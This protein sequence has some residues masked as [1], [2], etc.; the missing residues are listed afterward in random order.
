MCDRFL[1]GAYQR[2]PPFNTSQE[3]V[4][5]TQTVTDGTF[6]LSVDHTFDCRKSFF[7]FHNGDDTAVF[8]HNFS[9][10]VSSCVV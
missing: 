6:K 2:L 3:C 1:N 5:P 10:V 8:C 4:V 7:F 9:Y